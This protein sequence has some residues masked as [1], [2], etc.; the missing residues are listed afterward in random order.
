MPTMSEDTVLVGARAGPLPVDSDP[1]RLPLNVVI[2]PV[3][4]RTGL[5]L[6][7]RLAIGL[8]PNN[9]RDGDVHSVDHLPPVRVAQSD[10]Y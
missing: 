2:P 10:G 4:T 3:G 7:L 1:G 9:P 6:E 5:F 8:P